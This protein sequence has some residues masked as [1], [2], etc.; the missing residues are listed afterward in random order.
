M[1]FGGG[2]LAYRPWPPAS[3]ALH[4]IWLEL[5]VQALSVTCDS[6]PHAALFRVR[7]PGGA[8]PQ[9][10][11]LSRAPT[12]SALPAAAV[13]LARALPDGP[14]MWPQLRCAGR[15]PH[16]PWGQ[17]VTRR[18]PRPGAPGRRERFDVTGPPAHGPAD[19]FCFPRAERT[20]RV[21]VCVGAH[22][23]LG[24]SHSAGET[25]GIPPVP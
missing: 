7:T 5:R 13:S 18:D 24:S 9:T 19:L 6:V 8:L 2:L 15:R 23:A 16:Q 22:C 20:R 11:Q 4:S 25:T 3:Q 12:A 1:L 10:K 14:L 17:P 21:P